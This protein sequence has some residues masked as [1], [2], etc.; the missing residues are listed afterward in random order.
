MVRQE[1]NRLIIQEGASR[2]FIE[3]WGK[4]SLRVRMTAEP[5]MDANDWALIEPVEQVIPEII[6][7]EVD[8]TDPWYRGE[9]WAK[10]HQTGVVATLKTARSRHGSIPRAGSAFS[11]KG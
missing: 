11:T 3:C 10:Y 8:T 7:E 5:E 1:G 4:D 9:E 2:V 6:F